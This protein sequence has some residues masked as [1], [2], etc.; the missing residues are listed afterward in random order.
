MSDGLMQTGPEW[1]HRPAS[2]RTAARD[3]AGG[4][5]ELLLAI[6][7]GDGTRPAT[8]AERQAVEDVVGKVIRGRELFDGTLGGVNV[9]RLRSELK[10]WAIR[11]FNAWLAANGR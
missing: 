7:P 3:A 9:A 6:F 2:L 5:P 8:P 4:N 10:R 11:D 1:S